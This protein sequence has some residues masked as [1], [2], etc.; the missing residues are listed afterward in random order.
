[1]KQNKLIWVLIT[2]IV[3]LIIILG[4]KTF[5]NKILEKKLDSWGRLINN[6][7]LERDFEIYAALKENNITR[8]GKNLELNFMFHLTAIETD[9]IVNVLYMKDADRL[10]EKYNTIK[11]Q[12]KNEYEKKYPSSIKDLNLF[13]KLK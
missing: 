13:C 11:T 7:N 6:L 10:C 9:E 2:L 12:F 5:Q 8:V 4:L 1:M 3:I